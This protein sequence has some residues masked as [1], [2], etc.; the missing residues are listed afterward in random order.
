MSDSKDDLADLEIDGLSS[1]D[2]TSPSAVAQGGSQSC[3][4]TQVDKSSG[5]GKGALPGKG[6]KKGGQRSN[7][8][9]SKGSG[10]GI[11][12]T[13]IKKGLRQCQGCFQW[14]PVNDFP[15]GSVYCAKDKKAI[16]NLRNMAIRDSELDW[17]DDALAHAHKRKAL[18]KKYHRMV[19]STGDKKRIKLPSILTLKE[20]I[21]NSSE[22]EKN[23]HGEMMWKGAYVA[24]RKKPKNGAWTEREAEDHF[25]ELC[26]KKKHPESYVDNKHTDHKHPLDTTR[27]WVK[28]SD[29]VDFIQRHKRFK[30]TT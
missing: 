21:E 2:D 6:A 27:V 18:L 13:A 25:L 19:G 28:K 4:S 23:S 17:Y 26:D 15:L 10:K 3:G 24:F 22:V 1:D 16:Q 11:D 8:G 20:G 7:A 14:C 9:R 30:G 5:K 29:N 12:K